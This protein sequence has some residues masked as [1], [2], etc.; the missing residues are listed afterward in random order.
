MSGLKIAFV[1]LALAAPLTAQV[2]RSDRT[3]QEKQ[4]LARSLERQ[5]TELRARLGAVRP[6]A[7]QL[8]QMR[9]LER[10]LAANIGSLDGQRLW[11]LDALRE[12]SHDLTWQADEIARQAEEMRAIHETDWNVARDFAMQEALERANTA[13]H[14]WMNEDLGHLFDSYRMDTES[15]ASEFRT[16]LDRLYGD[17]P[18][19]ATVQQDPADSVY[20]AAREALNRKNYELAARLFSRLR[21]ES[22]FSRSAYR[23]DAYYW[24]AFALSSAG[25]EESLRQAQSVLDQLVRQYPA[26]QRHKDTSGLMTTVQVRLAQ[27]GSRNAA[28]Q[29]R[30]LAIEPVAVAEAIDATQAVIA[31]QAQ[32]RADV[33]ANAELQWA[34]AA[35]V[36]VSI[37]QRNAQCPDDDSEI[38]LIALNALVRMDTAAAMPVLRDVMSRRDEC[39]AA[40]RQSSLIVV[41]RIKTSDAENLLFEAARNDPEPGV[42][43]TALMHLSARSPDRAV[44]IAEDSLRSAQDQEGQEWALSTLARMRNDRAWQVIRNYAAASTNSVEAR[45]RAIGAIGQSSDS[46]NTAFLRDLYGRVGNER[47]LKEAILMSSAFRRTGMDADWLFRV[48]QDNAEDARLREYAVSAL[49]RRRD[50][51]ID[52]FVTLYDRSTDKRVRNATVNVLVDRSKT[53]SVASDKLIDIARNETDADL[54]KKAIMGLA[55]SN[56]PR[57][58]ELLIEILRK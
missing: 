25:S 1:A 3:V 33:R 4:E 19:A 42:R 7:V 9:Q 57:A 15:S 14:M 55:A 51:P 16:S 6:S 43:R 50:V 31:T 36:P 37:R 23:A 10:D 32:V 53:E 22:R 56:D 28:R 45:R 26:S 39:A 38:R 47:Q 41:S 46:A 2:T 34:L 58:R 12:Q 5:L 8:D 49:G 21:D 24:Q 48:A 18:R 54:R 35:G 40:L 17:G 27:L 52:R 11:S 29:I 44:A 30:T 20:R 13:E